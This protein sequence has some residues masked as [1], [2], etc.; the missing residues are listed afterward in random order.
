MQRPFVPDDLAELVENEQKLG[1]VVERLVARPERSPVTELA[2][3]PVAD[4]VDGPD[5]SSVRSA[6]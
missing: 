3:D 6:V 1:K 4:R 2:Q 5:A